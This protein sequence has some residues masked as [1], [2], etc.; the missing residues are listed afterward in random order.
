MKKFIALF[1]SSTVPR[2]YIERMLAENEN[3]ARIQAEKIAA[4]CRETILGVF[5]LPDDHD[6]KQFYTIGHVNFSDYG[7][8]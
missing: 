4:I 6:T 3:D 5:Q 1:H 8:N 7:N 2:V